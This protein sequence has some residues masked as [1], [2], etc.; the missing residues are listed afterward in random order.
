MNDLSSNVNF[1]QNLN[2]G[3]INSPSFIDRDV[4]NPVQ[5]SHSEAL[6]SRPSHRNEAATQR[7]SRSK[8]KKTRWYSNERLVDPTLQKR[9]VFVSWVVTLAGAAMGVHLRYVAF[10]DIQTAPDSIF[11][12][13]GYFLAAALVIISL[14]CIV[15]L[16]FPYPARRLVRAVGIACVV[17]GLFS[18]RYNTLAKEAVTQAA[19]R[20]AVP[21]ADSNF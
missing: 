21:A 7:R 13:M 19:P 10:P 14:P 9:L 2:A 17:V 16:I 18:F 4:E 8:R 3:V 6:L 11:E 20:E 15:S 5:S 12:V 1:S